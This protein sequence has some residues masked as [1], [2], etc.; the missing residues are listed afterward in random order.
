MKSYDY[1]PRGRV[2]YNS[3]N[4]EFILYANHQFIDKKVIQRIV[5]KF[6]LDKGHTVIDRTDSHYAC[7][8]C[9]SNYYYFDEKFD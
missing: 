4:S 5:R 6:K 1:F 3:M 2:V 8:K 9:N 7:D